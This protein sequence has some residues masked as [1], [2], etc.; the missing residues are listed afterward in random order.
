MVRIASLALLGLLVAQDNL[1][2]EKYPSG[3]TK[4]EYR[5]D[6]DGK[7]HGSYA[8][9]YESGKKKVVAT[10]VHGEPDG[11]VDH[12]TED[13]RIWLRKKYKAGVID[14]LIRIDDKGPTYQ[15]LFKRDG[16]ELSPPGAKTGE[17][18]FPR[19]Q[20]E[21]KT[22]VPEL[23]G[24]PMDVTGE[25]VK[26][27][28]AES[29][30][31]AS[32]H[33]AGKLKRDY[34]EDGLRHLVTYRWLSGLSTDQELDDACIDFCQHGAVILGV[35][36]Q[37]DHY[38]KQPADMELG[39]Y[40]KAYKGT[41]QSNIAS[42][43]HCL[44][45]AVDMF[46]DDSDPSNIDRVG[47]RM[48]ILNPRMKKTGFGEVEGFICQWSTDSSA[49]IPRPDF[50]RYPAAGYYPV[51][52]FASNAAWCIRINDQKFQL[53]KKESEMKVRLWT[54]DDEYMIQDELALDYYKKNGNLL[55]FR[56]KIGKT[57]MWTGKRVFVYITGA[58]QNKVDTPIFYVTEFIKL[59]KDAPPP[60]PE[61]VQPPEPSVPK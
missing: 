32:P 42:G 46:M 30:S 11:A 29:Y 34:L 7:K 58:K 8:E 56:P 16:I 10:Y 3:K 54:L 9:L 5:V 12:Y 25:N 37:L 52:Y 6:K 45:E 59:A 26:R 21:I 50:V 23:E 57:E 13:G 19:S 49:D 55:I 14:E 2:R 31:I 53:P 24:T 39:F 40:E 44:R 20:R 47:H 48:W 36:K 15:V 22:R 27:K 41:S 17:P 61:P 4:L 28:Y 35:I 60:P 43:S 38:P 51:E 18:A 33:V 1:V